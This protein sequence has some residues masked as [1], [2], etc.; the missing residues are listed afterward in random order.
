VMDYGSA[1]SKIVPGTFVPDLGT[2]ISGDE[3]PVVG[4]IPGGAAGADGPRS[5]KDTVK[6]M[7]EDVNDKLNVSDQNARDLAVGKTNDLEKV[8]SSVEEAN[9][10]LSFT[11][12]MR[13]KLLEAYQQVAQMQV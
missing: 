10:A 11:M 7:L 12:A 1:I 8:V 3:T 2:K 13:T 9:L 5:F 4:P 6:A